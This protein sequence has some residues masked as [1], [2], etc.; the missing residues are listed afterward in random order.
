MPLNGLGTIYTIFWFLFLTI[1]LVIEF[2]ALYFRK[3]V[4]NRTHD[5]GGTLSELVWR[6]TGA[7]N[8][9]V[10]K[11]RSGIVLLFMVWLTYH[12]LFGG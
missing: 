10:S 2:S 9:H 11:S 1:F 3:Y 6:F 5:S 12:F 4:P 8:H 7:A